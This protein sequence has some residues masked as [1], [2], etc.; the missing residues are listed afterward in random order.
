MLD[1]Y[2]TGLNTKELEILANQEIELWFS[3]KLVI[4]GR[5]KPISSPIDNGFE[6]VFRRNPQVM[7]YGPIFGRDTSGVRTLALKIRRTLSGKY[8]V[9]GNDTRKV[10]CVPYINNGKGRYAELEG[11]L[12]N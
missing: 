9:S 11:Y 4:K 3:K 8:V 12:R 2:R 10:F 6:F 1:S 5:L 7:V